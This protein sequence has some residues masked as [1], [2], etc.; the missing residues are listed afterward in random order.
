MKI[1]RVNWIDA[2]STSKWTHIDE[3]EDPTITTTVG[4]LVKESEA[5]VYVS[6]SFQPLTDHAG[7][8]IAIPKSWIQ[9]MYELK[10]RKP[11]KKNDRLN[12]QPTES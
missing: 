8:T 12:N 4:F 11:R 9:D 10:D 7:D 1:V 3:L 5:F 2:E 6:N